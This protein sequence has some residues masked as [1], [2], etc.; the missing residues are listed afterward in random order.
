MPLLARAYI[1]PI[2]TLPAFLFVMWLAV[3][4]AICLANRPEE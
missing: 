3:K 1:L 2:W 4:L